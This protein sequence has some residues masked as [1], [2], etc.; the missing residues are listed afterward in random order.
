MLTAITVNTNN[1]YYCSLGGIVFTRDTNTIVQCPD[2]KAGSVTIPSSATN[3][4]GAAFAGC[5]QLTDILFKGNAPTFQGEYVFYDTPATVY[6]LPGAAGWGATFDGLP[7]LCWNPAVQSDSAFGFSTDRFEFNIAGTTN[8]PVAVEATTNLISGVWTPLTNTTLGAAG[9]FR[10]A[11][12]G[13]TNL[14]A[15]FYRIVWP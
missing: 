12:P 14:P 6:Y 11:D 8:I 15:R 3:I 9:S 13:S 1:A 4:L 7:T 5:T 10:F 2:G